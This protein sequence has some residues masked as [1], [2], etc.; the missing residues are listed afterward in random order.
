ME[1][2]FFVLELDYTDFLPKG[3]VIKLSPT[4]PSNSLK[5]EPLPACARALSRHLSRFLSGGNR[6]A[7]AGKFVRV[8]NLMTLPEGTLRRSPLSEENAKS[9]YTELSHRIHSLLTIHL[10]SEALA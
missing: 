2:A 3:N 4:L 9:D 5:G 8:A 7:R 10:S 6:R 1:A